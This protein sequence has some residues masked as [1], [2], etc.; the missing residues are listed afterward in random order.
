MTQATKAQDVPRL[1]AC[2]VITAEAAQGDGA[3]LGDPG[4]FQESAGPSA[5]LNQAVDAYGRR[6]R[7]T[8]MR[9][10]A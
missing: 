1:T 8:I 6:L 7:L 5:L 9:L 4:L 2:E 3:T 10:P